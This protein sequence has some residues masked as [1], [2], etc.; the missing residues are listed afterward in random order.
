MLNPLE[1]IMNLLISSAGIFVTMAWSDAIKSSFTNSK[2]FKK[3]GP[4]AYAITLTILL[5]SLITFL[6]WIN[7]NV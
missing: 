5:F 7:R 2:R 3:V 6:F 4:W 1:Q